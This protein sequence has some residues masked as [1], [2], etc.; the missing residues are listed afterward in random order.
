MP[1]VWISR[2]S[3]TCAKRASAAVSLLPGRLP[4]PIALL[5]MAAKALGLVAEGAV[6]ALIGFWS[7]RLETTFEV[8]ERKDASVEAYLANSGFDDGDLQR[9]RN[10]LLCD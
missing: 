4:M 10:D 6:N 9:P 1:S 2:S 5:R 7:A 8:I 3:R